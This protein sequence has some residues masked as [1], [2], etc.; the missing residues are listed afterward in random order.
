MQV[1]ICH[2]LFLYLWECFAIQLKTSRKGEFLLEIPLGR[3]AGAS[4]GQQFPP[5]PLE[6]AWRGTSR[7]CSSEKKKLLFTVVL[8]ALELFSVLVWPGY[9]INLDLSEKIMLRKGEQQKGGSGRSSRPHHVDQPGHP[10]EKFMQIKVCIYCFSDWPV[11]KLK[12]G[13][14]ELK[15]FTWLSQVLN[16]Y[17]WQKVFFLYFKNV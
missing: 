1:K 7:T 13:Y 6:T 2:D 17:T 11:L 15:I 8:L 12:L 5:A 10:Y 3:H 9:A 14:Q 4:S 16:W